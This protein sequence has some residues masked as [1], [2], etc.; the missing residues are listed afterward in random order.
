MT[1]GFTLVELTIALIV[2]GLAALATVLVFSAQ[3]RASHSQR[4]RTDSQQN[5]RAA[6]DVLERE[7]RLA[8]TNVD[9]F[10]N[11]VPLVDAGA[12]QI[13]FNADA[14]SDAGGDGAMESSAQ[15]PLSDG[16]S[17]SPGDFLNENLENCRASTM[18]RRRSA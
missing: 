14:R 9:K 2:G 16:T 12:Y 18:E 8:G 7:V 5:A 4:Q 10:H 17:Y 3:D 6:M 11:Q 1:A 13:V 15:V